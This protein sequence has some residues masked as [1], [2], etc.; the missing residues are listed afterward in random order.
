MCWLYEME[1]YE[2]LDI[3]GWRGTNEKTMDISSD[4]VLTDRTAEINIF[5][6]MANE[7]LRLLGI[8]ELKTPGELIHAFDSSIKRDQESIRLANHL[9]ENAFRNIF[10]DLELQV[11]NIRNIN[12]ESKQRLVTQLTISRETDPMRVLMMGNWVD[13]SCLSY[14]STV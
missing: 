9:D 6:R 8:A 13:G 2:K 4:E 1:K 3:R 10:K 5:L 14:Y 11:S 12:R 7:K